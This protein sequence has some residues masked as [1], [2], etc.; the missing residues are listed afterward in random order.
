M[1]RCTDATL[2]L[3]KFNCKIYR[4]ENIDTS[5]K[6]ATVHVD[7][8]VSTRIIIYKERASKLPGFEVLIRPVVRSFVSTRQQQTA[9]WQNVVTV[10]DNK[11]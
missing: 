9:A 5:E 4:I 7:D 3:D 2:E 6:L 8:I 11:V 10:Y 1:K